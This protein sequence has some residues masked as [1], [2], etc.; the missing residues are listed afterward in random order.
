MLDF[1]RFNFKYNLKDQSKDFT[2][3]DFKMLNLTIK[4]IIKKIILIF[5]ETLQKS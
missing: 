2:H 3:V 1:K 5:T 4:Q